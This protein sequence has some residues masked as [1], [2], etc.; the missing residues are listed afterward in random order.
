MSHKRQEIKKFFSDILGGNT[1]AGTNVFVHRPNNIWEMKNP[2]IVLTIPKEVSSR[3][4]VSPIILERKAYVTIECVIQGRNFNN[5]LDLFGS[6][7]ESLV[8]EKQAILGLANE[9]I[10]RESEQEESPDGD[11]P[12]GSLTLVYEVTY[13][14]QETPQVDSINFDGVDVNTGDT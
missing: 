1:L 12:A 10:L 13:Y 11:R 8:V 14:T 6:Q 4:S 5:N 2:F 3:Y 9:L 7:I